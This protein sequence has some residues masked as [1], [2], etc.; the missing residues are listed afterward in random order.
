MIR[1]KVCVSNKFNKLFVRHTHIS[2]KREKKKAKW[3]N[4]NW[5]LT[6]AMHGLIC[7]VNLHIN[8]QTLIIDSWVFILFCIF[9]LWNFADKPASANLATVIIT[10]LPNT[11]KRG[12]SPFFNYYWCF[13]SL[14]FI[15]AA[16]KGDRYCYYDIIP[17]LVFYCFSLLSSSCSCI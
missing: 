9:L 7:S 5:I 2:S 16:R 3:I 17:V 15:Y 1:Y 4:G 12:T 10:I 14:N 6:F 13:T 8:C 11:S